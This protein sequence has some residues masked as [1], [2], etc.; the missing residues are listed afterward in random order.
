MAVPAG[1]STSRYFRPAAD[2]GDGRALERPDRLRHRPAQA[3]LV[4]LEPR[5]GVSE[6][7][8]LDAAAGGLDF[9]QLGHQRKTSSGSAPLPNR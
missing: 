7:V 9:G 4:H 8:R 2:G 1:T 5:H 3:R 6:E